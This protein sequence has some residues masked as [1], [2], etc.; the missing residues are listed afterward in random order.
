MNSFLCLF[1]V[2]RKVAGTDANCCKFINLFPSPLI[3]LINRVKST[4]KKN[5]TETTNTKPGEKVSIWYLSI[6]NPR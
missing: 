6:K 2:I 3:P 4:N 1:L 5:Y